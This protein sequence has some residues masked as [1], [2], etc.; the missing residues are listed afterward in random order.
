MQNGATEILCGLGLREQQET[1]SFWTRAG[2]TLVQQP[3]GGMALDEITMHI[4]NFMRHRQV[5]EPMEKCNTMCPRCGGYTG[6]TCDVWV[7]MWF[8]T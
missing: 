7:W 2:F 1:Q 5:L 3:R 6:T 4:D 8:I